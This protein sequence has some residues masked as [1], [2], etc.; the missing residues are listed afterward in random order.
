MVNALRL[1]PC[2]LYHFFSKTDSYYT[3]DDALPVI[4]S[5]LLTIMPKLLNIISTSTTE[6]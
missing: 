3:F 2:H 5:K 6:I 4:V 1:P